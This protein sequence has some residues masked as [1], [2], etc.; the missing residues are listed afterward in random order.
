MLV[1]LNLRCAISLKIQGYA[2]WLKWIDPRILITRFQTEQHGPSD[3]DRIPVM[4]SLSRSDTRSQVMRRIWSSENSPKSIT[5]WML[6][7]VEPSLSYAI[8]PD[9]SETSNPAF[10]QYV[11]I[12]WFCLNNFNN[13]KYASR[14]SIFPKGKNS[15]KMC[16][17]SAYQSI[18]L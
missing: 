7:I 4:V 5:S 15:V 16:Y 10:D 12:L 6:L 11:L 9:C 3:F 17:W 13:P 8:K 1:V 18:G 14:S 2:F